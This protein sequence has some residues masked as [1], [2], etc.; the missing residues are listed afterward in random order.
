MEKVHVRGAVV[1][2]ENGPG[3]QAVQISVVTQ[4][5]EW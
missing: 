2:E 5:R 3:L 4:G 1:T